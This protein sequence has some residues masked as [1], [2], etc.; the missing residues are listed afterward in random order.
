M[1]ILRNIIIK[2]LS[3]DSLNEILMFH[4]KHSK[5][6]PISEAAFRNYLTLPQYIVLVAVSLD[7]KIIGYLIIQKVFNIVDIIHICVHTSH[8]RHGI[9]TKLLQSPELCDQNDAEVFLEVATDNIA[10]IALY[11]R[12]GFSVLATRKK[13][14][15]SKDFYLMVK[16]Q[17]EKS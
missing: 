14:S 5:D 15:A 2:K 1:A 10:A 13:Y 9:A 12:C 4:V 3:I 6:W 17:H 7:C 16:R 11:K 8:R